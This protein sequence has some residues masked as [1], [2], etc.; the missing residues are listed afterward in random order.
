MV[1]AELPQQQ[2]VVRHLH[3]AAAGA[4]LIAGAL[5]S[6]TSFGWPLI[7]GGAVKVVYD[8]LLLWQFRA[9][10]PPEERIAPA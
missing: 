10:R 3:R 5:L 8:V 7:I 2:H 6:A 1:R 4:P 9:H